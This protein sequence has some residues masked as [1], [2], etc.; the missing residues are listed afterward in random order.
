MNKCSWR[1]LENWSLF[2]FHCKRVFVSGKFAHLESI[3]CLLSLHVLYQT[4]TAD[5]SWPPFSVD[6]LFNSLFSA[7]RCCFEAKTVR[8]ILAIWAKLC[9]E[10]PF[11]TSWAVAMQEV[12]FGWVGLLYCPPSSTQTALQYKQFTQNPWGMRLLSKSN[13]KLDIT[14]CPSPVPS[15]LYFV[16]YVSEG[17]S[18]CL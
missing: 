10:R 18:C 3:F 12:V 11:D 17:I 16:S 5:F 14:C 1:F 9:A 6:L 4:D 13:I 7:Q 2:L 15:N 8:K